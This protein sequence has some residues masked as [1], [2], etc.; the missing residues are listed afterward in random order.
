MD[1][2]NKDELAKRLEPTH[3]R[4]AVDAFAEKEKLEQ[5]VAVTA[6][7][8]EKHA[9]D[10]P[11]LDK[12][13]TFAFDWKDGRGKVWKGEFVNEVLSIRQRQ[14]VGVLRARMSAGVPID[15]L[16]EMTQEINLMIAH[17]TYSLIEK[18]EWAS[19]LQDLDD[20]RLLQELY[21]EV[22]VHEGTFF[23]Y[24]KFEAQS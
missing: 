14:L 18:P 24:Q 21:G 5:E 13:Y 19:D 15:S 20:I 6:G 2:V 1:S 3:L 7:E 23:G 22:L 4:D 12:K 9:T 10:K 11:R 8:A 17:M 16:D